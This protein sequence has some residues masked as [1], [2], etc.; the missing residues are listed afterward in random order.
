MKK[1]GKIGGG[2]RRADTTSLKNVF[3]NVTQLVECFTDNED[4]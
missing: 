1:Y 4:V 2:N 3:P